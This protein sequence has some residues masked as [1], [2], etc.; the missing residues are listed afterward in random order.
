MMNALAN[1]KTLSQNIDV[2]TLAR[3]SEPAYSIT[4][5]N[6]NQGLYYEAHGLMKLSSTSWGLVTYINLQWHVSEYQQLLSH[7][8]ATTQVCTNIS[9]FTNPEFSRICDM[10]IK[11]FNRATLTH[12]YE[13][14]SNYRSLMLALGYNP[15]DR[16]RR[17]LKNTFGRMANV[18]YGICSK[19]D[20][21]FL[22]DKIIEIGKG[23]LESLNL[24]QDNTRILKVDSTAESRILK[25]I[26]EH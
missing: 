10:F 2:K 19:V 22:M 23:K 7:Y 17:G 1:G 3:T 12:L 25:Q 11:Q 14:E 20:T 4:A 9:L 15:H 6:N 21:T 18:L 16:V 8:N 26:T 5:F 13:I 24:I